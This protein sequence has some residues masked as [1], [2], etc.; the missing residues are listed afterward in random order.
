MQ[1][2]TYEQQQQ[3]SAEE[4]GNGR[5]GVSMLQHVLLDIQQLGSAATAAESSSAAMS[6]TQDTVGVPEVHTVQDLSAMLDDAAGFVLGLVEGLEQEQLLELPLVPTLQVIEMH[7]RLHV[8]G[9]ARSH[10]PNYPLNITPD[11]QHYSPLHLAKCHHRPCCCSSMFRAAIHAACSKH[12]ADSISCT[13][14]APNTRPQPSHE[15]LLRVFV[16]HIAGH[17]QL[18]AAAPRWPAKAAGS[19]AGTAGAA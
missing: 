2:Q 10:L 12:Y 15:L 16:L 17:G 18:H 13:H 3:Q 8:H 14:L 9:P 4:L 1:E 6:F 5:T 11:V 7:A 19:D